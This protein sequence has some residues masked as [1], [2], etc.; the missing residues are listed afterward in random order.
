[1]R[2]KEE[3]KNRRIEKDMAQL[4]TSALVK[5]RRGKKKKKERE[6]ER[7]REMWRVEKRKR[8]MDEQRVHFIAT[9]MMIQG[10]DTGIYKNKGTPWS[11]STRYLYEQA[12][13]HMF[14]PDIQ[15]RGLVGPV[16]GGVEPCGEASQIGTSVERSIGVTVKRWRR[17]RQIM[18]HAST[19]S[20]R[21]CRQ[22]S[23]TVPNLTFHHLDSITN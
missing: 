13:K 6:R 5:S 23:P 10:Y 3:G 19:P 20:R 15:D 16:L 1:M 11:V 9:T 12:T 18:A 17:Q 22:S 2:E 8:N 14:I 4:E 21:M 7:E